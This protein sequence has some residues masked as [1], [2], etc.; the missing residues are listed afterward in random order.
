MLQVSNIVNLETFDLDKVCSIMSWMKCDP[1]GS[2][3]SED[4]SEKPGAPLPNGVENSLPT[5]IPI[6]PAEE[7]KQP[8]SEPEPVEETATRTPLGEKPS[9]VPSPAK[10]AKKLEKKMG[11]TAQAHPRK[12]KKAT[13]A[14]MAKNT[15]RKRSP[16]GESSLNVVTRSTRQKEQ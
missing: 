13:T 6:Q 2:T 16:L 9:N 7:A 12:R 1:I 4:R 15:R 10:P 11:Y 5:T 14:I 8:S 3:V